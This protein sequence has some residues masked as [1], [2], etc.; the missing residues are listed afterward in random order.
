ML[1]KQVNVAIK[2]PSSGGKSYLMESVLNAFPESAYYDLSTMSE[3]ALIYLDEDMRHRYLVIAEASGMQGDMQSYLI[4]T[5]LSEGR[6]RYQ[7]AEA[8]AAGDGGPDGA[9]RVH[10]GDESAPGERDKAV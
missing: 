10:H 5:L 1:D 6:I 4:R 9:A 7:T 2:G 8:A 3:K